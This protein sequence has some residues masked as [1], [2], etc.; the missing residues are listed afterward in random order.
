MPRRPR[1]RAGGAARLIRAAG[2][3]ILDGPAGLAAAGVLAVAA[4]LGFFSTL[5]LFGPS[6]RTSTAA[7]VLYVA[8]AGLAVLLCRRAS[9]A[10]RPRR[11]LL[12]AFV[13]GAAVRLSLAWVAPL[14]YDLQSYA[15]VVNAM[16]RGEV[17]YTATD[18]YNYSPLW[19]HVL[20]AT[21]AASRAAGVS[22]FF[23]FRVV[24]ILGDALVAFALWRLSRGRTTSRRAASRAAIWWTNPVPIAVSAYGGQ[25]DALAIGVLL[26]GVAF[27]GRARASGR[28]AFPALV[29]GTAIAVKQ[30]TILWLAGVLGFAR[31]G[32]ARARD[33]GLALLPFV[34][35]VGPYYAAYPGPVVRNVL[36]Y[37]SLHGLWGWY[38]LL[39]LF[40]GDLPFPPVFVSYAAIVLGSVLSFRL[41]ARGDDGLLAGR[42]A[43]TVFLALTPGWSF[44][45]L[46]W[47]L[48]F[49][50]ER[51]EAL[52]AVLYSIAGLWIWAEFLRLHEPNLLAGLLAWG[53]VLVWAARASRT[54]P[55]AVRP[56]VV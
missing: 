30:I 54:P 52:A 18:R 49:A 7:V 17:V 32:L 50:P 20:K 45:M 36:R 42:V 4:L 22:P 47:P 14:D 37:A 21:A 55:S 56:L 51:R 29:V 10:R 28:T 43:A 53:A 41:V 11:P 27:A 25:F 19:A 26:L 24:T 6:G 12:A 2:R 16:N 8:G 5:G 1:G 33:L 15:I 31:G 46:V 39:R 40:G 13:A 9:R 38:Y 44:Q 3:R 48:A 35:L 34:L 23:G